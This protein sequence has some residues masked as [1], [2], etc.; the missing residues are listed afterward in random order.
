[1]ACGKGLQTQGFSPLLL[2]RGRSM[3]LS[4]VMADK[5][6]DDAFK[7]ACGTYLRCSDPSPPTAGAT[8]A[9]LFFAH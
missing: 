6:G 5:D 4:H 8:S 3:R 2:D 7:T 1:M 9:F